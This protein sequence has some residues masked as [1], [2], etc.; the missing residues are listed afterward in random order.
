MVFALLSALLEHAVSVRTGSKSILTET[1]CSS[2][3]ALH[4]APLF[5]E[6]ALYV[7]Y[8]HMYIHICIYTHV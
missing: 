6:H 5:L 1:A 8:I 4:W 7:V 2:I 3:V